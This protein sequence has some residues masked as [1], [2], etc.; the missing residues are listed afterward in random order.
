M[1][2]VLSK[3]RTDG[4]EPKEGSGRKKIHFPDL[5][6]W[7]FVAFLAVFFFHGFYTELDYIRDSGQ[8]KF[9]KGLTANGNLGVDFFFVLS[10]FLIIYLLISERRATG[11]IDAKNF[12]IRRILRIF[13]LYYLCVGF[14][15]IISLFLKVC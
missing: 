2:I 5:D 4:A 11:R 12:Y 7:R 8:Y 14:G 3:V 10:G 1:R 13:P 15:F 6:G 9:V